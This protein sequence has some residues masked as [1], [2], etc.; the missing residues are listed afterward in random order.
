MSTSTGTRGATPVTTTARSGGRSSLR[1][2]LEG[3]GAALGGVTAATV[4][5]A[6]SADTI[7][8]PWTAERLAAAI[9]GA[10]L[11]VSA[12]GAGHHLPRRDPRAVAAAI[13]GMAAQSERLAS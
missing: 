13:A 3:L 8:P 10:R 5:M 9:P 2:E 12:N 4:V 1:G 7:M 11:L 6:D